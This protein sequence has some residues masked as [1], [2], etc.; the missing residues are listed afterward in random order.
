MHGFAGVDR[1]QQQTFGLRNTVDGINAAVRRHAVGGADKF[2]FNPD[3][4][5]RPVLWPFQQIST[6][7]RHGGNSCPEPFRFGADADTHDFG[8]RPV[9]TCAD[10]QP[11]QRTAGTGRRDNHVRRQLMTFFKLGVHFFD[12]AHITQCA[13]RRG[14][15]ERDNQRFFTAFLCRVGM[16]IHRP[17]NLGEIAVRVEKLQLRAEQF[18]EQKIALIG[19]RLM[20][21]QHQHRFHA[22]LTRRRRHHPGMVG[23]MPAGGDNHIDLLAAG[24]GHQIFQF[25]D[26][27]TAAAEAGVIITFDIQRDAE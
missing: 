18:I 22:E 8:V 10:I 1:I 15:A 6:I 24:I 20:A 4:V 7:L 11:G 23:L 21:A 17:F 27:I 2:V 25:A 19:F 9:F 3:I 14:A 12:S 5:R 13:E 26:F 16:G